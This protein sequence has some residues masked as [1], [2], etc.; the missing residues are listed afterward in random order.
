MS[1]HGDF[2]AIFQGGVFRPGTNPGLPEGARVTLALGDPAPTPE[3]RSH[4]WE[5]IDRIRREGLIRLRPGRVTRD[6]LYDRR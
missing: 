5:L 3:S 2:N 4:A 6:D 1:F